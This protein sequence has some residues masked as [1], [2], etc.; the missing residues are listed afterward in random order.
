MYIPLGMCCP[1]TPCRKDIMREAEDLKS[2]KGVQH[3]RQ[4]ANE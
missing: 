2:E 4:D 1:L 3:T